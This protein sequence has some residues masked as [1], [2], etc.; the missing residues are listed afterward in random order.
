LIQ[1]CFERASVEVVLDLDAAVLS[2]MLRKDG[3]GGGGGAM[4]ALAGPPEPRRQSP[5]PRPVARN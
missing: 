1:R 3:G 2:P 4:R 5:A